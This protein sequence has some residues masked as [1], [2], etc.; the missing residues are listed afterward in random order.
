MNL[1]L[2][3]QKRVDENYY[4]LLK[5][6]RNSTVA[7]IVKAYHAA[8]SAYSK[9]SVATYS[10]FTPDEIQTELARLEEAYTTLSNIEKRAQ[11]DLQ[12]NK[13]EG[14]SLTAI[15][16]SEARSAA[17]QVK[18][19]ETV[20]QDQQVSARIDQEEINGAFMKEAREKRGLTLDDVTRITKIPLKALT[21]LEQDDFKAL[22]A[23]VY[24]QGFIKNLA[25]LYKL[26]PSAAVK[27]YLV[28]LDKNL[29]TA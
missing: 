5:V 16:A 3:D 28:C 15:T 11:Y 21:A 6:S 18:I 10:L 9:D 12:L 26:D 4:E 24:C 25:V 20:I 1:A 17:T 22:P 14:G 8:K 29:P 27:A 7:E 2:L 23:R 19:A 13:N